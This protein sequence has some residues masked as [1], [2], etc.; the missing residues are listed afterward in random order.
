MA[1]VVAAVLPM[2]VVAMVV[3]AANLAISVMGRGCGDA[4]SVF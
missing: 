3:T 2:S 1:A 4:T